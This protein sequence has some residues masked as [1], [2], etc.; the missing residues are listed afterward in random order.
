MSAVTSSLTLEENRRMEQRWDW[1]RGHSLR[2]WRRIIVL[3]VVESAAVV[4]IV[5][6]VSALVRHDTD[7][8]LFTCLV[9]VVLTLAVFGVSRA[10][11]GAAGRTDRPVNGRPAART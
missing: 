9:A 1:G 5:A 4:N 2:T 11:I 7:L 6:C 8:G 3:L 10:T